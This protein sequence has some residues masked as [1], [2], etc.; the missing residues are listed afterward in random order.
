MT[1]LLQA[2]RERRCSPKSLSQSVSSCCGRLAVAAAAAAPESRRDGLGAF[3]GIPSAFL[4]RLTLAVSVPSQS[5]LHSTLLLLLLPRSW[6]IS[7]L[8]PSSLSHPLL[9][10][11]ACQSP[12]SLPLR[13][14][15]WGTESHE[16][17]D[18]ASVLRRS[19]SISL[20]PKPLCSRPF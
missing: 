10:W 3:F 19:H 18:L 15:S 4:S 16:L 6:L 1:P 17:G 13:L 11:N 2:T 14:I 20:S 12:L 9:R 7:L 8:L 5:L